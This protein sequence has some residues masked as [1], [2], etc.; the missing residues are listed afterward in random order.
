MEKYTEAHYTDP[1]GKPTAGALVPSE[2]I[3]DGTRAYLVMEAITKGRWNQIHPGQDIGKPLV[4]TC[5][6][7]TPPPSL[8]L[9]EKEQEKHFPPEPPVTILGSH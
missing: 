8:L 1:K 3:A 2:L 4:F 5:H 6:E 9:T 7:G